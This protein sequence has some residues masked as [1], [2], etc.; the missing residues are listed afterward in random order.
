MLADAWL[1]NLSPD[2]FEVF[3]RPVKWYG[4]SYVMGFFG[5][6]FLLRLLA[7]RGVGPLKK[8]E[9]SDFVTLGALCGIMVGGRLG[10]MLLYSPK[11]FFADPLLFFRLW[12]GGM[13][14]HGAIL[15]TTIFT[16][17]YCRLKNYNPA[18]LGDNLVSVAPLGVFFGRMANFINGELWGKPWNGWCA[19]KFPSEIIDDSGMAQEVR[20]KLN[21]YESTLNQIIVQARTDERVDAVLNGVLT[22][23][24][25]SQIYQGLME[26]LLLFV[27]LFTLRLRFKNL[28]WGLLTGIFFIGYAILRIIGEVF[29]YPD[30][31]NLAGIS[32]GQFFSL[33][34]FLI[35]AG[36]IA[37]A[38]KWGRQKAAS[39][40]KM[41]GA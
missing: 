22:A 15:A 8:D 12:E 1:H 20:A 30:S 41:K 33:F 21:D 36:F 14:S 4:L 7:V 26:G 39:F 34:M 18:R 2:I 23:R 32:K 25:P 24:H 17:V 38:M 11:A 19:V 27:V 37:Y 13:A 6:F 29:R 9:V 5:A 10:F 40:A 31:G 16:L 35:G 3:G 28:P